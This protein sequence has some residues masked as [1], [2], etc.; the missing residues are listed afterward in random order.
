M[1]A[2]DKECILKLSEGDIR[3]NAKYKE[4]LWNIFD[5]NIYYVNG[6]IN[7][8]QPHSDLLKTQGK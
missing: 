2:F 5:S 3:V 7:I 1:F 4:K 6:R 8:F